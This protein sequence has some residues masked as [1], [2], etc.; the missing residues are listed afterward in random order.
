MGREWFKKWSWA[1]HWF[2]CR[3]GD[4]NEKLPVNYE[5]SLL[6][7]WSELERQTESCQDAVN[8]IIALW[9]M[10]FPKAGPDIQQEVLA[11]HFNFVSRHQG[12]LLIALPFLTSLCW[13][14]IHYLLH[15]Q[16]TGL[17]SLS[18]HFNAMEWRWV[19]VAKVSIQSWLDCWNDRNVRGILTWCIKLLL[20]VKAVAAMSNGG[21]TI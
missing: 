4:H 1:L 20:C 8:H 3:I 10:G 9:P 6:D 18:L 21:S 19:K 14:I 16:F 15:S 12:F 13:K 11:H 5:S 7:A 17:C 2:L